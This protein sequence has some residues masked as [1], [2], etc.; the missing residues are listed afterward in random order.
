MELP[1]RPSTFVGSKQQSPNPQW[2]VKPLS[3]RVAT[4]EVVSHVE[5]NL[6]TP[7]FFYGPEELLQLGVHNVVF[8][9]SAAIAGQL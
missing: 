1:D 2:S 6:S 4:G 3:H 8:W 5:H 7:R 9:T